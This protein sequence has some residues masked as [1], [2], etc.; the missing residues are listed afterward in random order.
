[1]TEIFYEICKLAKERGVYIDFAIHGNNDMFSE[2]TIVVYLRKGDY[3]ELFT[4]DFEDLSNCNTD[5][6]LDALERHI[7]FLEEE[8]NKKN[9]S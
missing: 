6:M 2:S 9:E 3:Q 5:F 1:M 4:V 8:E 7:K